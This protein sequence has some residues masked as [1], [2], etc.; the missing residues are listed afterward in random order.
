VPE[1]GFQIRIFL[2]RLTRVD[3]PWMEVKHRRFTKPVVQVPDKLP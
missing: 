3:F 1:S 2:A